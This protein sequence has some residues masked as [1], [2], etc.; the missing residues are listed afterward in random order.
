MI[1]TATTLYYLPR[2]TLYF[3]EKHNIKVKT[4]DGW[5]L[6]CMYTNRLTRESYVRPYNMFDESKWVPHHL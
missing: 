2:S 1:T 6:G 5:S 4:L 3:V